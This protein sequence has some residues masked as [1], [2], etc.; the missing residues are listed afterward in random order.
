MDIIR[1]KNVSTH[2]AISEYIKKETPKLI[3]ANSPLEFLDPRK[4]EGIQEGISLFEGVSMPE[5]KFMTKW[6]ESL[7]LLRGCNN[8][9]N[10]CLRDAKGPIKSILWEDFLRFV[11]GFSKLNERLGFNVFESGVP[12]S[13]FD[14]S[15]PILLASN[16]LNGN[17]HNIAEA[18]K[19]LHDNLNTPISFVT[20]G[21]D[22]EDKFTQN[23]ADELVNFFKKMPDAVSEFSI[24]INPF[25]SLIISSEKALKEG[26]PRLAKE[27]RIKFV[28]N[29]AN[30][31]QT[32]L[33]MYE[34]K[35]KIKGNIIYRY[36]NNSPMNI[37]FNKDTTSILYNDIYAKLIEL[38]SFKKEKYESLHPESFK[39][40]KPEHLI[41]PKG[42]GIKY[43]NQ[44][45]IFK[46][47]LN[48]QSSYNNWEQMSTEQKIFNAYQ[49]HIKSI[50]INGKVY[51]TDADEI[52]KQ[53]GI[54]LNYINKNKAT[55]PL[56]SDYKYLPLSKEDIIKAC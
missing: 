10:H 6:F 39:E 3:G 24:S 11:N 14:D 25:H 29:I 1:F 9:C 52:V 42:R 13:L 47:E 31:L 7:N 49:Q 37:K 56:H 21:W 27:L 54:K 20:A 4:I 44:S 26:N 51:L 53:T 23:A 45:A 22:K 50:D 15:D 35:S 36:A 55:P 19:L 17:K 30:A 16:D 8:G 18:V 48:L 43:F 33:P 12:V 32:F 34:N 46:R 2:S 28:E 41:E 40:F 38:T 5:I